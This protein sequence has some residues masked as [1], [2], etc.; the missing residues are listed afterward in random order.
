MMRRCLFL[1]AILCAGWQLGAQTAMAPALAAS[2][3]LQDAQQLVNRGRLDEALEEL[4][5]LS[6]M[7]PEPAGVERLRG[8]I[9]YQQNKFGDADT[10]LAKALS[11]DPKDTEAMQLR[12]V[13]LFRMGRSA[14]AIPLLEQAHASI[15]NANIDPNYVLGVS[16]LQVQR[17]ADAR[18]AFAAQYGFAPDSAQAY[19]LAARIFF[20]QE[21]LPAAEESA[22]KALQLNPNLPLAHQ[23]MGEIQLARNN[24]TGAIAEFEKEEQIDPLDPALYDRLGDA[25]IRAGQYD[26]AQHA[27]NRA[28]LLEPNSTGPYILLAKVLLAKQNPMMASMYLERALHMDPNNY[29]AHSLLAQAYRI[30]GR[31]EDANRE[32]QISARLQSE[33]P[34]R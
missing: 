11:Q 5:A 20:R 23:L 21:F 8:F 6:Q 17:Y 9:F 1:C 33:N 15:P 29:I 26:K 13:T 7:H 25:Y 18:H 4:D 30:Q 27:L 28:V 32:F 3:S 12:G 10:A 24:T 2:P 31:R 16:Y 14:E 34:S 19:L 22:N